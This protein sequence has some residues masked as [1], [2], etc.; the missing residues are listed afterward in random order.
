MRLTVPVAADVHGKR[1]LVPPYGT[2]SDVV[3]LHREEEGN[4]PTYWE[5]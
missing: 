1:G 5:R 2:M 3:K 4:E